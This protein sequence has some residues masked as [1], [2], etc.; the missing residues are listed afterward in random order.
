M[1]A[2][3]GYKYHVQEAERAEREFGTGSWEHAFHVGQ[4]RA[5][6]AILH[7]ITGRMWPKE[8]EQIIDAM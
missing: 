3:D 8:W 2:L 4:Q 7:H 5:L 6:M 1:L